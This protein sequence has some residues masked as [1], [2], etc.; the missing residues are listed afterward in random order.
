[1]PHSQASTAALDP[2]TAAL[3]LELQ[4][5]SYIVSHDLAASFRHVSEFSRLLVAEFGAE[6]T[7][8]Q[9][10]YATRVKASTETCQQMME[11]L[12]VFSRVQQRIMEPAYKDATPAMELARLHLAKEIEA[13]GA[14]VSIEP[15]GAVNG[16][17][18]LLD[19]VF[20]ALLENAV[21]FRRPGVAPEIRVWA[22]HD[23]LSWRLRIAD[24]G[25]GVDPAYQEKAF[26]MFHR[27]NGESTFPGAGA[28]LA[29]S[30]R[31]ARRHEGDLNFV[32]CARGACIELSLP[33]NPTLQ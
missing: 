1:M 3:E 32:N 26:R 2:R 24:N 19:I 22:T 11:Q 15:L 17:P 33:L 4:A 8:P 21:K 20:R 10:A 27:L 7:G 6:L 5:F 18:F 28:G 30:R 16:D 14:V 23:L 9:Q 25:I 12:L 31:I 13:A 29:I